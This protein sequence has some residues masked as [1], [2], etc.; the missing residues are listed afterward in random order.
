MAAGITRREFLKG[1]GAAIT[2]AALPDAGLSAAEGPSRAATNEKGADSGQREIVLDVNGALHAVTVE[3][4]MTLAE[5]LRG[6]LNLTGTKIGCD[7][8]AC[9]A[10]TVW[11]DRAP[12]LSCMMLA[13]DIGERKVVTIEGLARGEELHP[14]QAAFVAH[15]AIQCGFCTPGLVMSCAALVEKNRNPSLDEIKTAITG[16]LCRCGTY[17]HVLDAVLDAAKT[18]RG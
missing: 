15:D 16:H 5:V 7:R 4:Q 1:A 17:P 10:C 8:G 3:P 13:V 11:V 9:S 14:V 18:M 12:V 6:P 2:G